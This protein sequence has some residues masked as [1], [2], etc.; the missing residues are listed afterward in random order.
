MIRAILGF[1]LVYGAVG[2]MTINDT[3]LYVGV[4]VA[5]VGLGIMYN[6]VS[7]MNGVK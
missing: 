7:N 5:F 1:L 3:P 2:S 4:L 6:G